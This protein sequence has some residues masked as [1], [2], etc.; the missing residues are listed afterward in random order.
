MNSGD[1]N[2]NMR[3]ESNDGYRIY[4]RTYVKYTSNDGSRRAI[5]LRCPTVS[6]VGAG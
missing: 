1:V 2:I 3:Y 4:R 5:R 6:T